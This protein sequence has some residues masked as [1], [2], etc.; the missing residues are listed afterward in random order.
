[1]LLCPSTCPSIYLSLCADIFYL[2][3][4]IRVSNQSMNKATHLSKLDAVKHER[5]L[6][7]AKRGF[8]LCFEVDDTGD[9][10][11]VLMADG[12]L[13]YAADT[14]TEVSVSVI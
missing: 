12:Q 4:A 2:F 10:I 1:M 6:A 7:I 11:L 13:N 5:G 3:Q 14:A 8:R 9:K